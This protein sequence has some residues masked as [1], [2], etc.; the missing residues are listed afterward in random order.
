LNHRLDR[1]KKGLQKEIMQQVVKGNIKDPRI[2]KIFSITKVKISKDLHY[3]H[4]FFSMVGTPGEKQRALGGFNRARG[5]FQK[6]IAQHLNLR[7]TPKLE[8]RLDQY[9]E[10]AY[11][12]DAILRKIAN[13]KESDHN[14]DE[15]SVEENESL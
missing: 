15:T 11:K 12:V 2:P 6:Y 5:I 8:F 4:I 9:E 13:E 14:S 7:F 10:Q 1:V 3:A